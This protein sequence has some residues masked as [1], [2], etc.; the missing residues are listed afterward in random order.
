MSKAL[1]TE[2]H[3]MFRV[4]IRDAQKGIQIFSGKFPPGY[5][6]DRVPDS[7]KHDLMMILVSLMQVGVAPAG[8]PRAERGNPS[9]FALVEIE[10]T[11][12]EKGEL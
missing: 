6:L 4:A 7:H 5:P 11:S 12:T 3:P 8:C 1:E 2:N 10:L 9:D